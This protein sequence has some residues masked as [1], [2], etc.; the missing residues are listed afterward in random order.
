MLN[1]KE[2]NY[3]NI[4]RQSSINQNFRKAE[5]IMKH[6]LENDSFDE[7]IAKKRKKYL[8]SIPY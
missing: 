6:L 1:L 8:L 3:Y 5:Q 4:L 2:K 7:L